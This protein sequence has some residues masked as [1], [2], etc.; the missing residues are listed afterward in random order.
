M[1]QVSTENNKN[2]SKRSRYEGF[3]INNKVCEFNKI[4]PLHL[5][6]RQ[7]LETL[8]I[9]RSTAKYW[10]SKQ[11]KSGFS[12]N[13]EQFFASE[14]GQ[15]FLHRILVSAE[16]VMNQ[17][18][19][20]GI[21]L[22]SLFL[23]LSKLDSFIA[24]SYGSLQKHITQ[25]EQEIIQ[26]EEEEKAN[27]SKKMAPKQITIAQDETFHP[28]PCLVAIEPVSN[29]IL[30]EKYS[31][32]RTAASWSNAMAESLENLPVE[33][34]QSTSDEAAGILRH[35]SQSFDA[36]KSPDLFHILQDLTWAIVYSSQPRFRC[37]YVI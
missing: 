26:Y 37:S 12:L 22:I 1:E 18:G 17:V 19:N 16:F 30:L 5:S 32:D 2:A 36:H 14:E 27:L 8:E 6:E 11:G 35:V 3:M 10:L 25:M 20:C 24:S 4:R 23:K 33:V 7:A 28:K 15:G 29:F 9:P 21:R 13:A 31:D 34:I